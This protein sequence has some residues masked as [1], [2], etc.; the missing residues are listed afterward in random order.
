MNIYAACLQ[1]IL[2]NNGRLLKL[3]LEDAPC[4]GDSNSTQREVDVCGF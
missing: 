2:C 1:I 3:K 4:F